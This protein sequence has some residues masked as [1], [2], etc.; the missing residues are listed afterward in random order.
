MAENLN[1][2]DV[3]KRVKDGWIKSWMMIEVMAASEEAARSALEKHVEA[4]GKEDKTIINKKDFKDIK[5]VENP[6]P[7]NPEIKEAYSNIAEIEILTQNF[8]RL[9]YLVMNYGPSAIEILEP[10][11]L[12]MDAGEAQGILTSIGMLLHKFAAV[13]VGGVVVKT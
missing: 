10:E 4:M 13:G 12:S 11:K 2:E 3:K 7:R 6:L 5:K 1:E 8:D 9:V